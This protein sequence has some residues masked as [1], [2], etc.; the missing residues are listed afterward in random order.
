MIAQMAERKRP[1]VPDR[2]PSPDEI[3]AIREARGYSYEQAAEKVGVQ[4]STWYG[5]EHPS[6]NRQP[7]KSHAILIWLLKADAL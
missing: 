1:R 7:S 2:I 5:W 4:P 3:R 6:Q